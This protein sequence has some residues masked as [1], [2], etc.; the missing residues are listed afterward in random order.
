M[1]QPHLTMLVFTLMDSVESE[2]KLQKLA[3][4]LMQEASGANRPKH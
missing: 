2:V 4:E 1:K 3:N